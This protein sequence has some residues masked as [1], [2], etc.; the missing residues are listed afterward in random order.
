MKAAVLTAALALTPGVSGFRSPTGAITCLARTG[1]LVCTV[2]HA[3]YAAA[4]QRRCQAPPVGLD[5]HGFALGSTG[6]GAVS[7]SGGT[8]AAGTQPATPVLAYGATWRRGP[9]ACTSRSTGV[10]C[11]A[12]AHGIFLSRQSW[13]VW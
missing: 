10:T 9:F 12:G 4:L 7:C 11:R 8:F 3:D 2:A 5:W 13:R 1:E 6:R